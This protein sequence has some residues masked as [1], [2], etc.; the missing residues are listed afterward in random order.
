MKAK[1]S[2][3]KNGTKNLTLHQRRYINPQM[4]IKMYSSLISSEKLKLRQI[5]FA[6]TLTAADASKEQQEVAAGGNTK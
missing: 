6:V 1:K 3:L 5:Y 2:N 4:H